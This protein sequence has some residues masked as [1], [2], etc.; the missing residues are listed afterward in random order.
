MFSKFGFSCY[1][2]HQERKRR[3][4][5]WELK[6]AINTISESGGLKPFDHELSVRHVISNLQAMV[7][8]MEQNENPEPKYHN[9]IV[10]NIRE[11]LII[12][13]NK[14]QEIYEK[15]KISR[16]TIRRTIEKFGTKKGSSTKYKDHNSNL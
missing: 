3:S 10:T 4:L 6:Q 7:T 1:A 11:D 2:F 13:N 15:N 8:Y 12:V 9:E 14:G 16:R 5:K